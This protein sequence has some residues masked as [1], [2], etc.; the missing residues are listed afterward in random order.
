MLTKRRAKQTTYVLWRGCFLRYCTLKDEPDDA[1]YRDQWACLR[2]EQLGLSPTVQPGK[3]IYNRLRTADFNTSQRLNDMA[4][5]KLLMW[6]P[7]INNSRREADNEL[8]AIILNGISGDDD[9]H[10]TAEDASLRMAHYM[11]AIELGAEKNNLEVIR[12]ELEP[13]LLIQMMNGA[14]SGEILQRCLELYHLMIHRGMSQA[15]IELL[16]EMP[17]T[18]DNIQRAIQNAA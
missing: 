3:A 5:R 15:A 2:V 10:V 8:L 6:T 16:G 7:T 12:C 13:S 18:E 17:L 4:R 9:P 11:E 14:Y 1:D